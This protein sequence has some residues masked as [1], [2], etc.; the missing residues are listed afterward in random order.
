MNQL[1]VESLVVIDKAKE[2]EN[3]C[4]AKN[5]LHLT[6]KMITLHRRKTHTRK[7]AISRFVAHSFQTTNHFLFQA[8]QWR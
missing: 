2:E 6:P 7:M 8:I 1:A 5:G 4:K 3:K